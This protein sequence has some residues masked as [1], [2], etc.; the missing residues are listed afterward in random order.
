MWEGD[1]VDLACAVNVDMNVDSPVAIVRQW[2]GPDLIT[3]GPDYFFPSTDTNATLRINQLTVARDNNR[4]ITCVTTILSASGSQFILQSGTT[5]GSTQLNVQGT[6]T[7]YVH[8]CSC[9]MYMSIL[10][11]CMLYLAVSY[12]YNIHDYKQTMLKN[13][14]SMKVLDP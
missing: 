3:A 9:V 6:S 4:V 7:A 11:V 2:M 8:V 14:H 5:S 12:G 1:S 10:Y 13:Q